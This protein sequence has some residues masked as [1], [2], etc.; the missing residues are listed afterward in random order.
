MRGN[1]KTAAGLLPFDAAERARLAALLDGRP[2]WLAAST[3]PG[4]EIAILAAHAALL[5]RHPSL[6]TIIVPRHPERGEAIAGLCAPAPVTR[7]GVGQDPPPQAG[8]WV[9]DT[10]GELGLFYRLAG[11]V[12][13]GGSLVPHG[14]QNVLEPA[15]LDCAIAVGPH[16]GNFADAVARLEEAGGLTRVSDPRELA[17]W[18]CGM[19]RG[20]ERRARAA[21]AAAAAVAPREDLAGRVAEAL[22]DLIPPSG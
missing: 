22:L 19:L 11:I 20:P 3:Q 4:E 12:F 18:V 6:L 15:R 2:V 17:G 21:A 7:R 5:P 9:A 14:G 8:V 10:L 16:T 13:V 1:L